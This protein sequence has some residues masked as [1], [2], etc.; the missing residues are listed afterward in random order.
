MPIGTVGLPLRAAEK[1]YSREPSS[2]R[3]TSFRRTMP[4]ASVARTTMSSN[5]SGSASRPS[6]VTENVK[7]ASPRLGASPMRPAAN[8]AFCSRTA[9]A[10][11]D[12]VRPSCASLSGRSQMRIE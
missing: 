1:L 3:A 5:C 12:G 4:P 6:V 2:T 10:T 11:S 7:S 9:A 8:C